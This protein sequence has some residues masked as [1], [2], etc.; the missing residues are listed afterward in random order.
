MKSF[1]KGL[2]LTASSLLLFLSQISLS[3]SVNPEI[4]PNLSPSVSKPKHDYE[5]VA[6][7]KELSPAGKAALEIINSGE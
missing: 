3:V 7:V 6:Y 2:F 5:K 4:I 1:N